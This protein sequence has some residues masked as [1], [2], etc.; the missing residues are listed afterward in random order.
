MINFQNIAKIYSSTIV[1]LEDVSFKIE[2]KEFVSI[3][4]KSGAGKTTLL[5]LLLAQEKPSRGKVF[6]D[7]QDVHKIPSSKIPQ[8]RRRIGSIFQDYKLFPNK[9]A[10][11]NVAYVLEVT[12]ASDLEISQNVPQVLEIVGLSHRYS[13]FPPELSG[14]ERQRVAIARALIHRPDV[15]LADEPTG[16]LDPYHT[17]EIIHLLSRINEMGTTIILATHNKEVVNT[18]SKR[19][20]TIEKGTILRDDKIGRFTL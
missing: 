16:N 17:R 4:G 7:N 13:N 6:F 14:G 19:V 2:K 10:Y 8:Y 5:K 20:I 11:E 15:I 1:A 9:T 3:V 18:L 12:G